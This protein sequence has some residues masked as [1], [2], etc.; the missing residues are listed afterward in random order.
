VE[1]TPTITGLEPVGLLVLSEAI[2][3]IEQQA[4]GEIIVS[5]LS[6]AQRI[7]GY[8]NALVLIHDDHRGAWSPP[9]A[10][11]TSAPASAPRSPAAKGCQQ[12]PRGKKYG[13]H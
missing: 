13:S 5:L 7:L 8:D 9:A 3:A 12:N 1:T 10:S 4:E 11:A 2:N 6:G